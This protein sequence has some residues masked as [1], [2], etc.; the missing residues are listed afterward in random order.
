[1]KYRV[2]LLNSLIFTSKQLVDSNCQARFRLSQ[3]VKGEV[4]FTGANFTGEI[5]FDDFNFDQ[6]QL[7]PEQREHVCIKAAHLIAKAEGA[8]ARAKNAMPFL[9][10]HLEQVR[11]DEAPFINDFLRLYKEE[12]GWR[13]TKSRVQEHMD[14]Y[15]GITIREI[16][17]LA[18]KGAP[19]CASQ[20]ALARV[21]RDYG[22]QSSE[23][24]PGK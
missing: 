22:L 21:D 24:E 9:K 7:S 23:L 3:E 16:R 18:A 15:N 5:V 6:R 4:D 8:Q 2:S 19:G 1:M 11:E 13:P 17:D 10:K 12:R 20:R 14:S